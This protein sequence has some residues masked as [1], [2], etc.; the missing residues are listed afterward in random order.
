LH[1]LDDLDS[2]M[3]AA[4]AVLGV[5]G[6]DKEWTGYSSALN[7]RL[8]RLE[9]F[10]PREQ[11]VAPEPTGVNFGDLGMYVAGAG[12]SDASPRVPSQQELDLKLAAAVKPSEAA[13]PSAAINFGDPSFLSGDND[14]DEG[15][16]EKS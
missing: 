11:D 9:V 2:K 3:A 7:R 5:T 4:R 1:Y 16:D 6:G 8:L 10:R 15:E 13:V 14:R 12:L